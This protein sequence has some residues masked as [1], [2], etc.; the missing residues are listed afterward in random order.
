MNFG[1]LPL[2]FLRVNPLIIATVFIINLKH[3][4]LLAYI[5]FLIWPQIKILINL[6]RI[7][8]FEKRECQV[9]FENLNVMIYN[10]KTCRRCSFI[11][12]PTCMFKCYV[13]Q[14]LCPGCRSPII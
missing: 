13:K 14:G 1:V 8:K 12:C 10:N 9:C 3:L 5:L 6:L 7:Y 11:Y 4:N 2:I